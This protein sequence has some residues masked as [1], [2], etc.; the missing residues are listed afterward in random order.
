MK[1]YSTPFVGS[2]RRR[3]CFSIVCVALAL[4][5]PPRAM[6]GDTTWFDDAIPA[7][8]WTGAE[9]G[10]AWNWVSSNP[11]PYSGTLAHQSNL[12]AGI[13]HHYFSSARTPLAVSPG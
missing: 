2:L 12:A 5:G 6:A 7:G 9:G 1:N 10:D 3:L 13:H 11:T 8:A 4:A